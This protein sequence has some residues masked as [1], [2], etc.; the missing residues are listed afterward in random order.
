LFQSTLQQREASG[1][2]I[3]GARPP[4]TLI[5]SP[6]ARSLLNFV[7]SPQ[8]RITMLSRPSRDDSVLLYTRRESKFI[9]NVPSFLSRPPSP[10][11]SASSSPSSP[12]PPYEAI[13]FFNSAAPSPHCSGK[14]SPIYPHSHLERYPSPSALSLARQ[15][16]SSTTPPSSVSAPRL[17]EA[18]DSLDTQMASLLEKRRELEQQLNHVVRSQSPVQNLP[19]E[20]LGL[21]FVAGVFNDVGDDTVLVSTLMLVSRYWRDVVINTPELWSNI[22]IGPHDSLEKASRKLSRSKSIPLDIT[23]NFGPRPGDWGSEVTANIVG[24][25]DLFR[26]ALWRARSF[27]LSVPNRTH[28]HSA[29]AH[30]QEGAPHLETVSIRV[31][32]SLEEVAEPSQSFSLFNGYTPRL[33]SCDFASYNFGWDQR[34]LCNLKVL[35]LDG[36]WEDCA[37]SLG[38]LMDILRSC[39]KL[40]E[41]VLRH[42]SDVDAD[43][44]A[45]FECEFRSQP[46]VH[47]SRLTKLSL[48]YCGWSRT[49][50]ILSRLS[51]PN[52]KVLVMSFLDNLNPILEQ[53]Q[54]QSRTS[55]PLSYLRIDSCSFDE[56]KLVGLLSSLDS[57]LTLELVDMAEVSCFVLRNLG[58]PPHSCPW[59]C[60][61]LETLSLD[62]C[63]S[64]EWEDL[65]DLVECRL[66]GRVSTPDLFAPLFSE[67]T[68]VSAS[69]RLQTH[70]AE[71]PLPSH[72]LV[73]CQLL[74]IDI[75]RCPQIS[76]EMVQWLKMYV[77]DV[78]CES[79][80]GT[81]G[82]AI[83]P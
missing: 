66:S 60:P 52:L 70:S 26:S 15:A 64:I 32:N 71:P 1:L 82:E 54:Q 55:L 48:H 69:A 35:Q 42:M 50:S 72:A 47:L 14:T 6:R 25:M 40:E 24:A 80:K 83:L 22:V 19:E 10:V 62:G 39:P 8:T 3:R 37:P 30:W 34:I 49:R 68:S 5:R 51:F 57:L 58:N 28:A 2:S 59:I 18:L 77:R 56:Q 38:T 4:P 7:L 11:S 20:L 78:H 13:P 43:E 12:P 81:W 29:L 73:P 63:T 27:R 23:I 76:K 44:V 31:F 9:D 41:L 74:C 79:T 33:R 17:R 65:R 75:T 46:T 36:Y 16:N 21:I 61:K 67:A 45:A 53:L